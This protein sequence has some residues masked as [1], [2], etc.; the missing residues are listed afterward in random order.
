M[1]SLNCDPNDE[2]N[3]LSRNLNLSPSPSSYHNY[4][5][6]HEYNHL[7]NSYPSIIHWDIEKQ[8]KYSDAI[9]RRYCLNEKFKY[10]QKRLFTIDHTKNSNATS[11]GNIATM[12]YYNGLES[13]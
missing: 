8:I 13:E 6:Y 11:I 12:A 4:G 2:T 5:L 9:T 1:L 10:I 7:I 3:R